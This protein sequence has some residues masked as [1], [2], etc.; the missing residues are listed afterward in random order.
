MRL[1]GEAGSRDGLG[2][3]TGA[4]DPTHFARE[5]ASV[6]VLDRDEQ[7]A[8]ESAAALGPAAIG[9]DD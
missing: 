6:A 5:G 3:R 7:A 1:E 8:V 4:G 2:R 9:L